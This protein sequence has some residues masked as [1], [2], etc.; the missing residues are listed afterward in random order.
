MKNNRLACLAPLL[1]SLVPAC[2]GPEQDSAQDKSLTFAWS[3]RG[4]SCA[5]TPDVQSVRIS[6]LGEFIVNNG[7]FPCSSNGK[8]G[9]TL[10]GIKAGKFYS[11]T[12]TALNGAGAETYKNSGSVFVQG[13][14]DDTFVGAYLH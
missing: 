6:I 2:Q 4:A 5:A 8:D 9:V 3:L 1:L 11:Y 14:N 7:D 10:H 12:I 13:S